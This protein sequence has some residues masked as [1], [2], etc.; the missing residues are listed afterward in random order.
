MNDLAGW[1]ALLQ[2]TRRTGPSTA[3]ERAGF[4]GAAF[5]NFIFSNHDEPG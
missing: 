4:T 5:N 1:T 3:S 2:P